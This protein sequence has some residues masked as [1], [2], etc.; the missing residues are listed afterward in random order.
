MATNAPK[1]VTLIIAFV[2]AVVSL[3]GYFITIPFISAYAFWILLVGFIVLA[4][5]CF[6]KGL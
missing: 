2:L 5:G 1:Q 6:I 4:A 3:L